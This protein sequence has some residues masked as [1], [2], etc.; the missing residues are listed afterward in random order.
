MIARSKKKCDKC[1]REI[2]LSNFNKHYEVCEG[3]IFISISEY[4][5]SETE[6]KCPICDKTFNKYGIK[7]HIWKEHSEDGLELKKE[8][9]EKYKNGVKVIWNKGLTKETNVILKEKGERLSKRYREGELVGSFK[10]KKHTEE[11][12]KKSSET[13]KRKL[14]EGTWHFS[15]SKTR[16]YEY[17]EVKLHGKWE[18]QYAKYLDKNNIS[19]RRPKEKFVYIHKGKERFY[20]PDF[21]LIDTNEYIEIKGYETEK[22]RSK[23]SQFPL[24]LKVIKGEEL[25]K[26][27]VISISQFKGVE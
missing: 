15:F 24:K 27:G 2:S 17:K 19:W 22:D 5:V 9:I 1:G 10:G 20:T 4:K 8:L 3:K 11:T 6:Y 12:R 13:I 23:W 7:T 25:Y 18:L 16:T 14:K 21:Y 26:L